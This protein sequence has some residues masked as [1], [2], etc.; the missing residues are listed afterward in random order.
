MHP[1]HGPNAFKLGIFSL[2]A[3]G[4]LALT[5]V[6]ERWLALWPDIAAVAKMADEAGIEFILPIARWK[7]FGGEVNNREW[8]YET[9]T[10]AAGLAGVTRL[11]AL[12]S[13]VHV[14]MAHPVFAAKALATVDHVSNGR[15]G[16]N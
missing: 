12:F 4:G 13:T 15:A 1:M 11:I 2:N 10:F 14:P 6:T 3:D 9:L 7:G 8:S 16:L 5:R